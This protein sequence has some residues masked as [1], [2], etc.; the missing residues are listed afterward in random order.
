MIIG[1][2]REDGRMKEERTGC[3]VWRTLRLLLLV[4]YALILT[5]LIVVI[6]FGTFLF[7]CLTGRRKREDGRKEEGC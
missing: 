7:T 4:M 1:K 3:R 6:Q 2:R 5:V